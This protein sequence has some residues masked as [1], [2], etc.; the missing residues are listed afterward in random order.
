MTETKLMTIID[1]LTKC[2]S[3]KFLFDT[4]FAKMKKNNLGNLFLNCLEVFIMKK[5]VKEIPK[6]TLADL[7]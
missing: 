7:M 5:K 6:E 3:Y 4:I 1:F 2:E